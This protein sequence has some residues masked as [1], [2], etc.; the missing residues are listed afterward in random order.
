MRPA[1]GWWHSKLL[2]FSMRPRTLRHL[3]R[4]LL[5][6]KAVPR[7]AADDSAHIAIAV[8]NGVTYLVT[9]N[10]RHIANAAMRTRIERVCRQAGYEPPVICTP[11]ELMEADR[12]D[13]TR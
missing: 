8:T 2:R 5:D 11:N 10:F 1:P 4:R 9:W 12:A 13:N 6:L 3:A 7:Q